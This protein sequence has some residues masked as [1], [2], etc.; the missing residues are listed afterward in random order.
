MRD[1]TELDNRGAV[2]RWPW[3]NGAII[4][5]WISAFRSTSCVQPL[6][7]HMAEDNGR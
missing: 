7:K 1:L 2:L 3:E 4:Q 5:F 6:P